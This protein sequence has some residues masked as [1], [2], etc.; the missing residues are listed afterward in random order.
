MR[1]PQVPPLDAVPSF[2]EALSARDPAAATG[3]LAER[4]RAHRCP[5][6]GSCCPKIV[7]R[8][9]PELMEPPE[10][11]DRHVLVAGEPGPLLNLGRQLARNGP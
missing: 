7:A 3:R 8:V 6:G 1:E 5:E 11:L 10:G 4:E 2:D 9:E